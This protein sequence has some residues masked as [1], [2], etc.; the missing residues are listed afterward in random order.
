MFVQ[1]DLHICKA[2]GPHQRKYI[3][4]SGNTC[5]KFVVLPLLA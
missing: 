5:L 3:F 2:Q 4:P 1:N